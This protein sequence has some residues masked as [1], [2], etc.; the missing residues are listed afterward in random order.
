MVN[1]HCSCFHLLPVFGKSKLL[2]VQYKY[3][4]KLVITCLSYDAGLVFGLSNIVM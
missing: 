4:I 3:G 2:N 1:W